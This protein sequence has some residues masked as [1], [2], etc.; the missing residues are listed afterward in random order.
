MAALS[1]IACGA[2]AQTMFIGSYGSHSIVEFP[3]SGGSSTFASGL[4]F[5]GAL[6]FDSAGDLFEANTLGGEIYEYTDHNGTLN[7]S[8][9]LFASGLADPRSIAFDSNGNMFVA[10]QGN[11]SVIEYLAGGGKPLTPQSSRLPVWPLTRRA[12]CL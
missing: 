3:T 5:P 6:A 12:T 2:S 11:D 7:A 8:A 1:L 9:A 10:C 4:D